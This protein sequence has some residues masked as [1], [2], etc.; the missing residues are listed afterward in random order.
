MEPVQVTTK[1]PRV[2][3]EDYEVSYQVSAFTN[4]HPSR[5]QLRAY[6]ALHAGL[7]LAS[8]LAPPAFPLTACLAALMPP[9]CSAANSTRTFR[10]IHAYPWHP[11]SPPP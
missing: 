2:V 1:V 5:P 3:M 7:M 6:Y 9:V 8:I 11:H 4:R 10:A